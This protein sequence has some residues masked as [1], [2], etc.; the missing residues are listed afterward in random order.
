MLGEFP[1]FWL[2]IRVSGVAAWLLLTFV[3]VWGL[4][5]R[6]RILG[7]AIKPN[8]AYSFHLKLGAAAL[9]TLT[10]HLGALLFDPFINFGWSQIFIPGQATWQPWPVAFGIF[11]IWAM[12]P[13]SIIGRLRTK[14]GKFGKPLYNT[15]HK[16]SFFA[17]PLA[18]LHYIFAG[19]DALKS[20]SLA[21][22][23]TSWLIIAFLLIYRSM[24]I[25]KEMIKNP[26]H[27]K[28]LIAA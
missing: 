8:V 5:L 6:T 13:S 1:I 25:D 7:K 12:I 9:V 26:N 4:L 10:V 24:K 20:W 15:S 22:L 18:T 28:E 23:T 21:I 27:L 3:V 11:A 2:L 17:W 14:M 19:T 16:I